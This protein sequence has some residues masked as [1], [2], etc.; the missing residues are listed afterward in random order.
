METAYD[1]MT[2]FM[3]GYFADYNRY[4]G[5]ART[6]PKMLKYY[7]PGIQLYSYTLNAKRPFGLDRILLAMTHPGLHEEFTPHYYVVDVR[8][9]VVVIQM[10]N[11]FIEEAT[12]KAYPPKQLSVH[13]YLVNDP[14]TGYKIKKILFY[15]EKRPD[16]EVK[17]TNIIQQFQ[18]EN[19][20]R[21]ITQKEG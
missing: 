3:Q 5:D 6:L 20:P 13:Y 16:D 4:G 8:R 9:K 12:G 15:V 19:M 14:A 2:K 11:Q 1:R 17:M 18:P 10:E 21:L 7:L